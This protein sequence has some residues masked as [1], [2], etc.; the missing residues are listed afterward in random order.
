MSLW[1]AL[2]VL[3][4]LSPAQAEPS[5]A[6]SA[7][8]DGVPSLA[9]ARTAAPRDA[10][11]WQ[12]TVTLE[13][14]RTEVVYAQLAGIVRRV[15][16][17]V[18]DSVA[19]GDTLALLQDQDLRLSAESAALAF[20]RA[21]RRWDRARRLHA[22]GGLS[23]QELEGLEYTVQTA[24][25]RWQQARLDLGRT[26][27]TASMAGVVSECHVQVGVATTVRMHA[28]RIIDPVDLQ[29]EVFLPADRMTGLR[30]GQT[31]TAR[32]PTLQQ[33]LVGELVRLSPFVDPASG[34]CRAV[35]LF[36]GAGDRLRPG[37]V[38]QVE[39][40]RGRREA[41]NSTEGTR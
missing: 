22:K 6:A 24:R 11:P 13:A 17:G 9:E 14:A 15:A 4:G 39:V 34:T 32:S 38:V 25:I 23:T 10:G 12:A 35:V 19:A 33:P 37:S 18:G 30:R 16:V 7:E 28:F 20:Q 26:V 5:P 8:A 29:A 40:G 36:R 27:L 2:L 31:V 41:T 1:S 3:L 21:Q